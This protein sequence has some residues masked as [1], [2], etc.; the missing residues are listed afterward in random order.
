MSAVDLYYIT[1]YCIRYDCTTILNTT[2][3][4]FFFLHHTERE[5][6]KTLMEEEAPGGQ[7]VIRE[8]VS[9]KKT[10]PLKTHR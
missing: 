10:L 3:M 1:Y 8:T 9:V 6:I 7:V 5:R 2:I 4:Y